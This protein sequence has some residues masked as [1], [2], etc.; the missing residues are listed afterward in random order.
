M[1]G[2]CSA[3]GRKFEPFFHAKQKRP[4]TQIRKPLILFSIWWEV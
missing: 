1:F 4:A 2:T 3:V